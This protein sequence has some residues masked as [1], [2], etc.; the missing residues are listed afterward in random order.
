M[1]NDLTTHRTLTEPVACLVETEKGVMVWPIE[2][3]NVALTY[4]DED[5]SP[6]RLYAAQCPLRAA[7]PYEEA[8][9]EYEN[10]L[11]AAFPKGA[12]GEAF[13]HWNAARSHRAVIAAMSEWDAK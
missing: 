2:D 9:K 7:L 4:C 12:T 5:Q 1:E 6:I 10:A 13:H 3:Y 8:I 11:K